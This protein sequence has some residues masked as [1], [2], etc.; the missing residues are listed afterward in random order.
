[1]YSLYWKRMKRFGRPRLSDLVDEINEYKAA[2]N[3]MD[4]LAELLDIVH[5]T[6][7]MIHPRLGVLVFP[8]VRKHALRESGILKHRR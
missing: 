3:N 6:L 2:S 8:V 5:T 1:M 4:K 7:R